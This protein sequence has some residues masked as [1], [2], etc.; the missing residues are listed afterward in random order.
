M[1]VLDSRRLTGPGL[2]LDEP[3]AVL[4][5]R[6]EGRGPDK[7]IAAWQDA[8]R[9]LLREV[10]WP[11]ERLATRQ[12]DGGVSLA[13]TAPVDGLYAAVELNER[14]LDA[15]AAELGEGAAR[16][17]ASD[18]ASI[19]H[20]ISSEKNHLLVDL[21]RA[22]RTRGLTF[23][24]G[25]DQVSVGSGSGVQVWPDTVLPEA[26]QVDWDRI[27]DVPIALV[28]GSNGKT[29]VVRLLAA[30]VREAGLVPGFSSTDGVEV[31]TASIEEGDFSGPS[32]ARLVLRHPSVQAAILEIARGGLL[33][34]GLAVE[35]AQAAVV[36]NIAEDHLGE[37]GIESLAELVETK[38]LVAKALGPAGTL[39]LNADDPLL[40]KRS[41]GVARSIVWFSLDA[42]SPFIT[43][44]VE[45]GDT[46]VLVE[47]NA[48]VLVRDGKRQSLAQLADVP[49]TLGGAARHN[50]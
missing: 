10:G 5:L 1:K 7:V 20:A 11:D 48:I 45:R 23:L 37:F 47:K 46:A 33:R 43:A 30:M 44:H 19:R 34:R 50:V 6:L 24:S 41:T 31:G 18:V 26:N 38:L 17:H 28:T 36:T 8:A 42:T 22:A 15:A 16:D 40:V 4:D 9:R 25:E 29:T 39:V 32:G 27:Y 35:A 3:G 49:I 2:L 21:R 13:L 14:A 12:F